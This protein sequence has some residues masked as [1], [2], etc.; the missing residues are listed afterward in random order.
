[1]SLRLQTPA[2]PSAPARLA[3]AAP[4]PAATAGSRSVSVSARL[5]SRPV[6]WALLVIACLCFGWSGWFRWPQLQT[7][8]AAQARAGEIVAPPAGDAAELDRWRER[9]GQ[10]EDALPAHQ[11]E[12]FAWLH[13]GELTAADHGWSARMVP[14]PMLAGP[15][16]APEVRRLPVRIELRDQRGLVAGETAFHRVE[17]WLATLPFAQQRID[18]VSLEARGGGTGLADLILE[19][20]FWL[21]R[22]H[23]KTAAE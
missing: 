15:P 14:L 7:P 22:P 5:T 9:A 11:L 10:L 3:A 4:R 20:H 12:V 16:G 17:P 2:K 19:L 18:L 6:A 23:E 13:A 1:M 8:V 21:Q